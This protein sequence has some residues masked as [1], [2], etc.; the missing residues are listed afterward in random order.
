MEW[1]PL[2]VRF[3]PIADISGEATRCLAHPQHPYSPPSAPLGERRRLNAS[4]IAR[5]KEEDGLACKVAETHSAGRR[6]I[7]PVAARPAAL[8]RNTVSL[9]RSLG[10]VSALVAFGAIASFA[11][12]AP[13]SGSAEA[14]PRPPSAAVQER[15]SQFKIGL[16]TFSAS[17]VLLVAELDQIPAHAPKSE[18]SRA[19]YAEVLPAVD[20]L[21]ADAKATKGVLTTGHQCTVDSDDACWMPVFDKA[22]AR[23]ADVTSRMRDLRTSLEACRKL[24]I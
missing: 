16:A 23:L 8:Q 13:A 11:S 18:A 17:S 19:C 5:C 22:D 21:M 4:A 20:P 1:K 24:G 10:F 12:A 9:L 6:I 2:S 7:L 15:I 3:R 14:A